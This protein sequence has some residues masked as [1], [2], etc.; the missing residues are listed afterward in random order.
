MHLYR[1]INSSAE[2]CFNVQ[3]SA[4][5]AEDELKTLD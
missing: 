5:L 2:T 4:P 3:A 1:R